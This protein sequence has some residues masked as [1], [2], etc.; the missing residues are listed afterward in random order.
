MV[1][2]FVEAL[3]SQSQLTSTGL[4]ISFIPWFISSANTL[5]EGLG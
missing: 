5:E 3:L 1:V 4:I 2:K